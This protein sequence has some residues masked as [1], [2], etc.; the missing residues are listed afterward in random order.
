MG[1]DQEAFWAG[2]FGK[3][4][5]KRND[6][7]ELLA[8][9][10]A[11]FAQILRQVG[12]LQSVLEIGANIGLNLSALARLFP[13]QERTGVEINSAAHAALQANPDASNAILGA[14]TEV[15]IEAQFD[16]VLSTGVLIHL[17]PNSLPV[18]YD[19]IA[20]WTRRYFLLIEYYSPSPVEIPYRGHSGK[21]FKR[22][23]AG[24]FL[25]SVE[26]FELSDYGFAYH[27]AQPHPQDDLTWFLLERKS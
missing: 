7:P 20:S 22:D 25:D 17:L 1:T 3:D 12:P 8:S 16:L 2:E 18:V 19:H 4:Y 14:V 24:E 11:L 15:D 10:V 21:L 13:N 26:G 5:I 23:F 6:S 9:K 27:R